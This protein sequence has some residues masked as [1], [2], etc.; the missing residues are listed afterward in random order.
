MEYREARAVAFAEDRVLSVVRDVT[1]RT[2]Q[3]KEVEA[4]A[5]ISQLCLQATRSPLQL[6]QEV[7]TYVCAQLHFSH[8]SLVWWNPVTDAIELQLP[9]AAADCKITPL[10]E[11]LTEV[12]GGQALTTHDPI[13]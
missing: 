12:I 1:R 4:L 2:E 5:H 10:T 13:F 7:L 3:T 6:I 8:G 9:T 11:T